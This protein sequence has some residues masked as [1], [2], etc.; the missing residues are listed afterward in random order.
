MEKLAL[1]GGSA[2]SGSVMVMVSV[3][4]P[5]RAPS[6]SQSPIRPV[7]QSSS[8][9]TFTSV[10]SSPV[11]V[12]FTTVVSVITVLTYFCVRM[13]SRTSSAAELTAR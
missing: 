1:T 11:A 3:Q 12:S 10:R 4:P 2:S 9:L 13:L 6:V 7:G 8:V 5:F